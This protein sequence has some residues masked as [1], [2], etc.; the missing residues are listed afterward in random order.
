MRKFELKKVLFWVGVAA[1]VAGP[2]S[3]SAGESPAISIGLS[4]LALLKAAELLN[5]KS[6]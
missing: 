5:A 3:V 6:V 2:F 1:A 4:A